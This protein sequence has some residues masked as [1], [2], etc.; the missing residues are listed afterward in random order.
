MS[1][2]SPNRAPTSHFQ[3]SR[4]YTIP[5]PR[6]HCR[7]YKSSTCSPIADMHASVSC[8]RS[9]SVTVGWRNRHNLKKK[10]QCPCGKVLPTRQTPESKAFGMHCSGAQHKDWVR[11]GKVLPEFVLGSVA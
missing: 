10:W 11:H 3:V 5:F 4:K 8:L 6:F 9:L 1:R 7:Y 2:F